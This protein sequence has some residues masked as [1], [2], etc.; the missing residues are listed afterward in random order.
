MTALLVAIVKAD[1]IQGVAVLG[2]VL[3]QVYERLKTES[4]FAWGFPKDCNEV[5]R[6]YL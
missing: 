2:L 5:K 6:T 3:L 1:M 4:A